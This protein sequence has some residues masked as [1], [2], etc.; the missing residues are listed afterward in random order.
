MAGRPPDIAMRWRRVP[1]PLGIALEDGVVE[2]M[3]HSRGPRRR[4][5]RL[6]GEALTA[7]RAATS[8]ADDDTLLEMHRAG[9]GR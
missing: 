5:D 8:H 3:R 2:Q 4:R 9:L 1:T 6:D 7:V